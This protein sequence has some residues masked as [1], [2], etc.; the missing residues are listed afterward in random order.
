MLC[1]SGESSSSTAAAAADEPQ[2]RREAEGGG[3]K[4]C[5]EAIDAGL[6]AFE[7]GEYQAAL[8]LFQLSL[9]LPGAGTMRM[10]GTVHEIACPSEGQSLLGVAL[11]PG[12][13]SA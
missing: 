4:K 10:S 13:A 3:P 12:H 5:R 6:A 8:D 1:R 2:S 7:Q 9:E 11:L